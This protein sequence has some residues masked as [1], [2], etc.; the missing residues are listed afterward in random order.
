VGDNIAA[1]IINAVCSKPTENVWRHVG[2]ADV[3]SL[4]AA[5]DTM[6]ASDG[7]GRMASLR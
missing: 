6:V 2:H 4:G 1:V 7:L 5:G 3:H